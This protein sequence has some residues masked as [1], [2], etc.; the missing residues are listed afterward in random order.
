[1]SI[2]IKVKEDDYGTFFY[3]FTFRGKEF[4]CYDF[5]SQD[6]AVKGAKFHIKCLFNDWLHDVSDGLGAIYRGRNLS[7]VPTLPLL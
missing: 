5:D 2:Q 4:S 1:M 3:S 6:E 7:F